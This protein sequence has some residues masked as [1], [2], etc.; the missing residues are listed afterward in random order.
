[1]AS[2]GKKPEEMESK[3]HESNEHEIAKDILHA[4][5]M[6]DPMML[7]DALEAHYEA[8]ESPEEEKGE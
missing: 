5:K 3:E 7:S 2:L 8:C 4:I 1:M 6:N